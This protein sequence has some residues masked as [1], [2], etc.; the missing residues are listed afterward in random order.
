MSRL[1]KGLEAL[2]TVTED[3]TKHVRLIEIDKIKFNPYQPRGKSDQKDLQELADSI[4]KNGIIQPIVVRK[5]DDAEY[6]YELIAGQRRLNAAQLS[7]FEKVPAIVRQAKDREMLELSI[8]ENIQRKNLNPIDEANAYHRLATEFKLSQSQIAGV[9]GKKRVTITNSLRLLK[10]PPSVK[11]ML[12]QGKLSA[13]H[14]RA[15]L[16][17][18]PELQEEFALVLFKNNVSVRRAEQLARNF[19]KQKLSSK[20]VEQDEN[21]KSL[22]NQLSRLLGT[23]IKITGTQKGKIEIHFYN[24]E[25]LNRI[26][27]YL[28]GTRWA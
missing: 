4:S 2:I 16:Q 26:I 20:T 3:D 15:I 28:E 11:E 13:G 14:A 21:I 5:S 17:V 8:V 19:G 23:K 7:G 12:V 9:V 27:E 6:E 24:P 18:A 22:E 25:E 1:G 10:L